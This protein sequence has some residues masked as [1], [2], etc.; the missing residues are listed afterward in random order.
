[1]SEPRA[2]PAVSVVVA[3]ADR[4]ASLL[5]TLHALLSGGAGVDHEV[6]VV[7]DASTDETAQGLPMLQGVRHLRTPRR[8]GE[9]AARREGAALARGEVVAFLSDRARPEPGWLAGLVAAL[10]AVPGATVAGS[11]LL[12]EAGAPRGAPV[13]VDG[14][15]APAGEGCREV[16]AVAAEA[17]AVPAAALAKLG[18]W[19]QGHA[20]GGDG[21]EL[22]LRALDA[23]GRVVLAERSAVRLH[24]PDPVPAAVAADEGLLRARFTAL[25]GE[26]PP[27]ARPARAPRARPLRV[28]ALSVEKPE[29][30]CYQVRLERPLEALGAEVELRRGVVWEGE[31]ARLDATVVDGSD[32]VVVQRSFPRREVAPFLEALRAAGLPVVYETDDLMHEIPADN[33]CHDTVAPTIPFIEEA[34][35]RADLVTVTT[36]VL[37]ERIARYGAP[38]EIVPNQLDERLWAGAPPRPEGGPVV[39]GYAGTATHLADLAIVEP[40]LLEISRRFGSGVAFRFLGCATPQ[41]AALPNFSYVKFEHSYQA[42]ARALPGAGIDVGVV[43]LLDTPFNACKSD[44]K[45]LE[46]AACGI[47]GV[48]SDLAPYQ[49]IAQGRTGLRVPNTTAAWIEALDRLVRDAALRRGV[50][51]AARQEVL[52]ARTHAATAR[53]QL[54]LYEGLVSAALERRRAGSPMA[55][56]RVSAP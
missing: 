20:A 14:P 1:M 27:P 13:A 18:G 4:W 2:A 22:C 53:R 46:Y 11:R 49:G 56:P 28:L 5:A 23:G 36:P 15:S 52:T 48:F 50:A 8:L 45:W 29:Y 19:P 3:S 7:D 26:A 9:A 24:G 6:I 10:R 51:A 47:A 21:V 42:Y 31:S 44:I 12:D 17:L 38:I 35:R 25:F 39:I 30:A 32:L 55:A 40:A 43:P 37:A 16:V 33:L 34:L 41:L 54:A